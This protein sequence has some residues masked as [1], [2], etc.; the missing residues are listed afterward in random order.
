MNTEKKR[1]GARPG[2]GPKPLPKD[3]V[4]VPVVVKMKPAQ[5]EKLQQLGG[6]P[7]VRDKID[8]A[9]LPKE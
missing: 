6:A 3:Q 5:K 8:K 9:K 7:W 4:M 1:G 2:S